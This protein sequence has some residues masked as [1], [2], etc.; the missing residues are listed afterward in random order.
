M[1]KLENGDREGAVLDIKAMKHLEP[2]H[3]D[4]A[5]AIAMIKPSFMERMRWKL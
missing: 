3:P 5:E 2:D 1:L 4:I